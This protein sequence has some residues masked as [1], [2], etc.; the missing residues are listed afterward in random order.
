LKTTVA[1]IGLVL[2]ILGV[3]ALVMT[4]AYYPY[5]PPAFTHG[6]AGALAAGILL[7]IVSAILPDSHKCKRRRI[8]R[9]HS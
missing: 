4:G 7:L 1:R 3:L 9:R 6:C 5:T 8:T 2:A